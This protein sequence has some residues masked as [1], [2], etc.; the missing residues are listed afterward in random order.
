MHFRLLWDTINMDTK[1]KISIY[2]AKN[3]KVP[4]IKWLESLD[5]TTCY[6]VKERL[7]RIKKLTIDISEL[8]LYF[9]SGYRVYF[10]EKDNEVIL[11]L[12]A[13]D[14]SSQTKDIKKAISY[15][16]DYLAQ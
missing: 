4:F 10:A 16:Q 14:K 2:I 13:G 6:R 5:K 3:G 7:D 11:L 1:Y 9:G 8:R 15:W 12:C